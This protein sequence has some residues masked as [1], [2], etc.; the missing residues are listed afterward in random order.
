MLRR[1]PVLA[2][3]VFWSTIASATPPDCDNLAT[4]A[5]GQAFEQWWLAGRLHENGAQR[6]LDLLQS[7]QGNTVANQLREARRQ[8]AIGNFAS[9]LALANQAAGRKDLSTADRTNAG[10]TLAELLAWNDRFQ[11]ARTQA[12]V[13]L[14]GADRFLRLRGLLIRARVSILT[15]EV[16]RCQADAKTAINEVQNGFP[17]DSTSMSRALLV[18]G[19]CERNEGDHGAALATFHRALESARTETAQQDTTLVAHILVAQAQTWKIAG[20]AGRA[21]RGYDDALAWLRKYPEPFPAQ[22]G[23][24]LHGMANLDRVSTDPKLRERALGRYTEAI[25][26]LGRAYGADSERLS[27]V[28]NNYGNALGNSGRWDDAVAAYKRA[29][30]IAELH[31]PKSSAAMMPTANIAMVRM[32]QKRYVEAEAG[33]RRDIAG[34]EGQPSGAETSTVFSR[35]GLAAALWG[36][37]R[38]AEA[39]SEA[40]HAERDRQLALALAM[41]AMSEATAIRYKEVQWPTLELALAIAFASN[42]PGLV[43]RAWSLAMAARGQ[44]SS[45]TAARLAHA[46]TSKNPLLR[47]LHES[48]SASGARLSQIRLDAWAT[49]S[50]LRIAED[51]FDRAE[52]A[53]AA[54][55][56]G[57]EA[58]RDSI[59][60]AVLENVL[61]ANAASLAAFAATNIREPHEYQRSDTDS[62]PRD[63]LAFVQVP[64]K[65]L[66]MV[67]TGDEQAI[68]AAVQG[69]RDAAG[70]PAIPEEALRRAGQRVRRIVF[71]PLGIALD[72]RLMLVPYGDLHQLNMAALP[73]GDGY[74]I[75]RGLRVHTLNHERELLMPSLSQNAPMRML[76]VSDPSYAGMTQADPGRSDP[77]GRYGLRALPGTRKEVEAIRQLVPESTRVTDLH[78]EQAS[79]AQVVAALPGKDMVHIAAHG[80]RRDLD[81]TS[82]ELVQRGAALAPVA[83]TV[84][85]E[86]S[87]LGIL[88]LSTGSGA[89]ASDSHLGEQDI[90]QLSL[91]GTRWVVLSACDSG[92]GDSR[93]Y[94]GAFGLRRAFRLAGARSVIM[95]LWQV[96]DSATAEWMT[97]LYKARLRDGLSTIESMAAAQR[98]TLA[99]RRL[100]SL[101]THPYWWAGFIAAGDWR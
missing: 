87:G 39:F 64:G 68:A 50:E 67:R 82:S 4:N 86:G 36:E 41:S 78:G 40:E 15:R 99:A 12:D 5:L 61:R 1:H 56:Q 48:W 83:K 23:A 97:A 73:D 80:M 6:C 25:E 62:R 79:K 19:L 32:W 69:W 76:A 96:D 51:S 59:D 26:T 94:E 52:Q 101:D 16:K 63:V 13:E 49:D 46:R 10:V 77:C 65:P 81:C 85:E 21:A 29:L 91:E 35:L 47:S 27:H 42:D 28:W 8:S 18:L 2:C 14:E 90:L 60:P 72:S 88:A 43:A 20:D 24:L 100:A 89:P 34:S 30:A 74:L 66:R 7:T 57:A 22:L 3:L 98:E 70:D 45:G 58:G 75:D 17:A 55:L 93:A 44:I 9:S 54:A 95:S 92:L 38:F 11:E 33:F 31:N 53:L 84:A 37:G 71:D